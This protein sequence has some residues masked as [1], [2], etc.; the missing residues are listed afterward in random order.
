MG[1]ATVDEPLRAG[2]EALEQHAWTEAFDLLKQADAGSPLDPEDLERLAEAGWWAA[3]VE[4]SIDARERAYA[5]YLDRGDTRRAGFVALELMSDHSRRLES[6]IAASWYRRAERHLAEDHDC[7]EYGYLVLSR[8]RAASAEA[9]LEKAAELARE[10][11]DI[12][13]RHGDP[14]LQAHALME[15]GI[16]LVAG[17]DVSEGLSLVDEATMAAVSG[18]L[19]PM[20][21]G[22]VYC[23]TISTCADLADYRRA[24]EW[25]EAARRWCERQ[26]ISGF[27]GVCRVHRAEIIRLRGNWLEA[28]EEA[29]M[30]CTELQSH[31]MP[32]QASSGFYEVGEIRLRMGD[33]PA[34]A[35]ALAQA[36]ELGHSGQPAMALLRLA[37]GKADAARVAITRALEDEREPLYRARLLPAAL[38][39]A[40]ARD[41]L[42][43][44]RAAAEELD[45]IAG[46]FGS[47]ALQAMAR[48]CGAGVALATRDANA[49][50]ADARRAWRL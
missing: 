23:N 36:H 45:D 19:S 18:E 46:R 26:A 14:D 48:S 10:A 42:V 43:T 20:A 37:E 4:E 1:T 44:A 13:A 41:D 21:T 35:E 30:A 34:A 16:N 49:A 22:I 9:N 3:H 2:R 47:T 7:A 24:G 28:E 8:A 15:Q 5:A 6:S 12:G 17:G 40:L 38:E 33:L 29:R 39:I 32:G 11:V 31:G 27:P 50:V 25:T